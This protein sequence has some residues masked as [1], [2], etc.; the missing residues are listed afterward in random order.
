MSRCRMRLSLAIAFSAVAMTAAPVMGEGLISRL[1]GHKISP[2]QK[3]SVIQKSSP[4]QKG[5]TQKGGCA[6]GPRCGCGSV[7]KGGGCNDCCLLPALI[8]GVGNLLDEIFRCDSCCSM[9]KGGCG[10]GG[11]GPAIRTRSCGC[12]PMPLFSRGC[13]GCSKGKGKG[14]GM[15]MPMSPAPAGP[16]DPFIED[17]LTPPPVPVSREARVIR[18]APVYQAASVIAR[19]DNSPRTF[20]VATA[21]PLKKAPRP[22]VKEAVVVRAN[23]AEEVPANPLRR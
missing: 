19:K 18:K 5:V 9:G 13:G 3:G 11:C 23:N 17:N 10:K 16:T 2:M 12:S 22:M 14:G 8:T 6:A 4:M 20:S 7:S 1:A 21:R 15:Y